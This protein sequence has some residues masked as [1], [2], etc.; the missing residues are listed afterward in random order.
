MTEQG[1]VYA[2]F[3]KSQLGRESD[4]RE[5]IET[6]GWSL[7]ASS[8]VLATLLFAAIAAYR[9]KDYRISGLAFLPLTLS[10]LALVV[11]AAL[12]IAASATWK[13]RVAASETMVEMLQS[14]W[15]DTATSARN[16]CARLDLATISSVRLVNNRKAFL[17]TLGLA[18]ELLAAIFATWALLTVVL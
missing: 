7:I 12:G 3:I 17:L 4:R 14:H 15:T 18:L 16:H 1:E 8:G 10:L 9:G 11:S 5:R 6:R 13:Y 2:D